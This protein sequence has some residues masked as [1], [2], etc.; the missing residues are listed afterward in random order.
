VWQN[1]VLHADSVHE[2]LRVP[3]DSEWRVAKAL[4]DKLLGLPTRIAISTD[5]SKVFVIDSAEPFVHILDLGLANIRRS[6]GRS[7]GD[8]TELQSVRALV[9]LRGTEGAGLTWAYELFRARLFPIVG[10]STLG[11]G[12]KLAIDSI[13]SIVDN[14]VLLDDGRLLFTRPS[15]E[16]SWL[17]SQESVGASLNLDELTFRSD[18]MPIRFRSAAD[19]LS[20][21]EL[22]AANVVRSCAGGHPFRVVRSFRMASRID[23]FDPDDLGTWISAE[24]PTDDVPLLPA[25]DTASFDPTIQRETYLNCDIHGSEILALY[26]GERLSDPWK[27][28]GRFLHVFD[29][30]S[31]GLSRIVVLPRPVTDVQPLYNG[32]MLAIANFPLPTVYRFSRPGAN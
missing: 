31:G 8:S 22:A 7:G 32:E 5:S 13:G 4:S 20:D 1:G 10:D 2:G 30:V 14:P 26:S 9:E 12:V 17:V 19:A 29:A 3:L 6:F 24:T 25:S 16:S 15:M 18:G 21:A 27:G 11:V 28:H 23:V